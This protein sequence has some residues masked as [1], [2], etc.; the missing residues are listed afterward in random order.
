VKVVRTTHIPEPLK[1]VRVDHDGVLREQAEG[2]AFEPNQR[3][4]RAQLL[5]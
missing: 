5:D 1:E 4:G 3:A 2:A